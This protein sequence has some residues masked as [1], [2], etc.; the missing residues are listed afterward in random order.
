[1]VA[2]IDSKSIAVKACR[3]DSG[4]GYKANADARC[5]GWQFDGVNDV[6][7]VVA[8][9]NPAQPAKRPGVFPGKV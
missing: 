4:R 7:H 5:C 8:G 9:S 6:A 2:T 3:F 1:M